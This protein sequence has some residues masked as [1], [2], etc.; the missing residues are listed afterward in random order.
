[1]SRIN[2]VVARVCRVRSKSAHLCCCFQRRKLVLTPAGNQAG[3]KPSYVFQ[4]DLQRLTRY[5]QAMKVAIFGCLHGMLNEMYASVERYEKENQVQIDFVLVCGDCQTIRHTDDLRCIAIPDKY[6]EIGDFHEYYAGKKKIPKLTIFVGG[7]HEA[8]NYLMTL[9]YGGWV[10]D[11]FYFLG[12]SGVV[13]YRG[14]RIAGISGIY[15]SYSY[16]RGRFEEMPLNNDTLRSIYHTRRLDVFRLQL[17]SKIANNDHIDVFM[18]HDWPAKIYEYGN[19]DQLLRFKPAFRRDVE[20]RNGLGNPKTSPL[21]D[22]LKPRRWFAAHLHC[23]F[24]AKKEHDK[25]TK[26][27][28]EFLSLNKIQNKKNYMEILDIEPANDVSAQDD[29]ELYHDV[30]WLTI[31]RKTMNLEAN[32]S[33]NVFCPDLQSVEAQNYVPTS[34]DCGETKD[35]M[36]STG[37]LQIPRNFTMSEPV[38]YDRENGDNPSTDRNRTQWFPNPQT[39]ELCNRLKLDACKSKS[40]ATKHDDNKHHDEDQIRPIKKR[41][42]DSEPVELD[43]D[44]CL[45]F[46][47]DKKGDK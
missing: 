36:D 28:T 5:H 29:T 37:G 7:N 32:S 8:S 30:D 15:N 25:Q 46:Y 34:E 2:H 41:A 21:V 42:V 39:V 23:R 10:C 3:T 13:R 38:I 43:E 22:L 11:N 14:L 16:N 33:S 12:Y 4:Q 19:V 40:K 27:C 44:G 17:L 24:Y 35:M 9:P 20:S 26:Q 47:I 31:L 45:M 6:K 18:S 1:M